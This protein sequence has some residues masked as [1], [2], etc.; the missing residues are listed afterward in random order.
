MLTGI[1][2]MDTL[3]TLKRYRLKFWK[4]RHPLYAHRNL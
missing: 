2:N 4:R 3:P 1:Y